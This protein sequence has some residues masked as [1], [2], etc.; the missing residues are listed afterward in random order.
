MATPI[1]PRTR[2]ALSSH[3]VRGYKDAGTGK[4]FSNALGI[5]QPDGSRLRNVCPSKPNPA[6]KFYELVHLLGINWPRTR[7]WSL[8]NEATVIARQATMAGRSR[9]SLTEEFNREIGRAAKAGA[10]VHRLLYGEDRLALADACRKHAD[11]LIELAALIRAI[12][13]RQS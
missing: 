9:E 1:D 5:H 8:I 10:E 11:H 6:L 12:E 7:P 2:D 4:A 3:A 13:G